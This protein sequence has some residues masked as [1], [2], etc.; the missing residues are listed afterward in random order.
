MAQEITFRNLA[1]EDITDSIDLAVDPQILGIADPEQE[2]TLITECEGVTYSVD[3]IGG[4]P[5]KRS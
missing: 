5:K 1:A 4:R 2:W 3:F